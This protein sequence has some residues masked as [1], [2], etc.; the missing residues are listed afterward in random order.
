[1]RQSILVFFGLWTA[2]CVAQSVSPNRA[3]ECTTKARAKYDGTSAKAIEERLRQESARVSWDAVPEPYRAWAAQRL[4]LKLSAAGV[5]LAASGN[6]KEIEA[7][8]S[9][10]S[11]LGKRIAEVAKQCTDAQCS[12][13][14]TQAT[15]IDG[16]LDAAVCPLFPFC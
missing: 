11:G 13:K 15:E 2:A 12:T 16:T 3:A 14:Q 8:A 10:I 4:D 6:C 1:M 7:A 9:K 5:T